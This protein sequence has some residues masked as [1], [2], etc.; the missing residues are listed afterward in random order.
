MTSTP[1]AKALNPAY[2]KFKPLRKD[3]ENF[4]KELLCCIEAIVLSDEKNE[5]EEHIKEPI[6]RFFQNTFYQKNLINTISFLSY[7]S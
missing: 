4:K 1:I 7:F 2:R 5:S 3:I 6:K